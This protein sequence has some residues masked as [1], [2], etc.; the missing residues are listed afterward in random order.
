MKNL[1]FRQ[2]L[3][4]LIIVGIVFSVS[5]V[6]VYFYQNTNSP[7]IKI[8]TNDLALP[9][10]D[11]AVASE[12]GALPIRLKIF[13]I[14]LDTTIERV[15]LTVAGAMDTPKDRANVAWL[16]TGT[17]P[18][19]IGS[20]VMAGHYGWN[21]KRGSAFDN[22]YKLRAGDELLVLDDQGVATIF[23]VYDT[24]RYNAESDATKV[25]FSNDGKSHLNL[26]TCEGD[27]DP[28]TKS[29]PQRLVVFAEA[30]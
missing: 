12:E 4:V 9:E 11:V 14:N 19:E 10:I 26:I 22:L 6:F 20:A 30:K 13:K 2:T 17:R 1:I 16:Q 25:F 3:T 7:V 27:W 29:Y 8:V 15:G 24:R 28:V 21:N 18:G 23:V 5:L